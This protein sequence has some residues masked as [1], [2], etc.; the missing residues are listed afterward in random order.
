MTIRRET[1]LK[2]RKKSKSPKLAQTAK[3]KS[4]LF[5]LSTNSIVWDF[6]QQFLDVFRVSMHSHVTKSKLRG[7]LAMAAVSAGVNRPQQAQFLRRSLQ[8]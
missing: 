2:N 5:T 3:L 7:F 1:I 8:P 4:C 6:S